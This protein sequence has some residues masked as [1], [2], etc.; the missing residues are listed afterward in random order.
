MIS[1][2]IRQQ[3]DQRD[4]IVIDIVVV[5]DYEVVSKYISILDKRPT[6]FRHNLT[7]KTYIV[8]K[9]LKIRIG[10]YTYLI[11]NFW[12]LCIYYAIDY[13]KTF[14]VYKRFTLTVNTI[15]P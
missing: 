9:C 10:I 7:E 13:K 11:S 1:S 3:L 5:D 15:W 8:V 6:F 4:S 2:R 14:A 12:F